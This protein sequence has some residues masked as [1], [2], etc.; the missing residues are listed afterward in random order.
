MTPLVIAAAQTVSVAGDIAANLARHGDFIALA[1][2]HG[3]QLLVFPELSLTGYEL[4]LAA[5]LALRPDSPLLHGL[6]RQAAEQGLLAVVGV[7]L[8]DQDERCTIGAVVLGGADGPA[9]YAKQHLHGDEQSYFA[10]GK[11]KTYLAVQDVRVALA[12][13]ADVTHPEHA[14]QAA[15]AG[16]DLYVAGMVL[17][18]NGY[19]AETQLLQ[20]YSAEHGMGVLMANHGGATGGWNVVGRSGFW[21]EGNLLV[22]APGD[23][24]CLVI[25]RRDAG[26]W[27]G[28]LATPG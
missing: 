18:A 27:S 10:A 23:G 2:R 7:P 8:L 4:K 3:V 25:A 15:A 5:E 21:I 14:A 22:D 11:N 19:H 26:R 16:A 13:C 28:A 9:T 1:G 6:Q 24:E 12:I 17:T 20:G